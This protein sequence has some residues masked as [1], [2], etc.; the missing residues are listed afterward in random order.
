MSRSVT[1]NR[2]TMRVDSGLDLRTA[3]VLHGIATSVIGAATVAL[4]LLLVDTLRGHPLWTPAALGSRLFLGEPYDPSEPIPV[5]I[6]LGFTAMH[7]GVFLGFGM[8]AALE[9]IFRWRRASP[10]AFALLFVFLFMS[11][12]ATF[13]TFGL[14][15]VDGPAP[16]FPGIGAVTAATFLA[17]AAMTAYLMRV[18]RARPV[19]LPEEPRSSSEAR[20]AR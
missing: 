20:P 10:S 16:G 12:Q 9:L 13:L 5:V 11:L 19:P 6:V 14:V 2:S 8:V 17:A 1:L 4:F 7:G 18:D 15:L 3:A